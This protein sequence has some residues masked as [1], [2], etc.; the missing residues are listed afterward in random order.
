MSASLVGSEMCIRDSHVAVPEQPLKDTPWTP[1]NPAP[2]RQPHSDTPDS[3][4]A[5]VGLL[6]GFWGA[7]GESGGH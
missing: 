7:P 3:G 4:E 2:R 5:P 6:V 1:R